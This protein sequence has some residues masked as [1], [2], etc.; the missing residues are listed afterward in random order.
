M[1]LRQGVTAAEENRLKQ[2]VSEGLSWNEIVALV[3]G[4]VEGTKKQSVS[5]AFLDGVDLKVVKANIYDPLVK[6]LADAK[7]A[8]HET[9]HGHEAAIKAEKVKTNNVDKLRAERDELTE[10]LA[11]AKKQLAAADEQLGT[12]EDALI[13]K[14]KKP[15]PPA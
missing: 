2:L 13:G 15:A 5:A 1:G 8:G 7:K 14:K 10:Q 12:S 3:A 11:T 9:I 4:S 6:K